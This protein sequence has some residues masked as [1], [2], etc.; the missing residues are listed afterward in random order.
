VVNEPG[1]N[2]AN[3]YSAP[4]LEN[5]TENLI[6]QTQLTR[7]CKNNYQAGLANEASPSYIAKETMDA[8]GWNLPKGLSAS[9]TKW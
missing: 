7:I 2:I 4:S 9:F 1:I 8:L 6:T 3:K 5:I